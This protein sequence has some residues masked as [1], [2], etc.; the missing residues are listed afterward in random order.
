MECSVEVDGRRLRLRV[1]S[2]AEV[3]AGLGLGARDVLVSVLDPE[4]RA[5]VLPDA[6]R[7]VLR[8][9]FHDTRRRFDEPDL[10]RDVAPLTLEQARAIRRFVEE[11]VADVDAITVHCHQGMSRSPA[12]AAAIAEGLGGDSRVWFEKKLPN[13]SVHALLC[14]VWREPLQRGPKG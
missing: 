5:L 1:A 6:P 12:V 13:R 4:V 14:C 9:R 11:H 8:L 7:A 2:R 3:E 10:P